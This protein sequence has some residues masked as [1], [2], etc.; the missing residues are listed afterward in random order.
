MLAK[1]SRWISWF[2]LSS[3][4]SNLQYSD[5]GELAAQ[6]CGGAN[7]VPRFAVQAKDGMRDFE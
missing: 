6:L 2:F 3:Q 7:H 5:R 4:M 1:A